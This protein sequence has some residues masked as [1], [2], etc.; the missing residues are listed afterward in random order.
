VHDAFCGGGNIVGACLSRGIPATGSDLRDRGY[1]EQRDAFNITEPFDNLISNPPFSLIEDIIPHFLPLVRHKMILMAR[2]NI[3]E[4]I[5]RRRLF[6][7]MPPVRVW[8]S[9]QRISCPP[10][11]LQHPR[12]EFGC[13][14]PLPAS[15]G[16]TTYCWLVWDKAYIGPT[17]L[18]WLPLKFDASHALRHR[19][20]PQWPATPTAT[21]LTLLPPEPVVAS[22]PARG[23]TI[24]KQL[25]Q[26]AKGDRVET[27]D[28][29]G[30]R[31]SGTIIVL[32]REVDIFDHMPMSDAA[33]AKFT[34]ER[35]E[36]VLT[37]PANGRLKQV[38]IWQRVVPEVAAE[39]P[40]Q[41]VGAQPNGKL[42]TLAIPVQAALAWAAGPDGELV[43]DAKSRRVFAKDAAGQVVG[44]GMGLVESRKQEDP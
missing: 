10:G 8:V 36:R 17:I 19:T 12:D 40:T 32:L 34:P 23:A 42:I 35:L 26:I 18:G 5:E 4:G 2:I 44:V 1:G 24:A 16:T 25:L 9:S 30:A 33:S 6:D 13:V 22:T 41:I 3:L 11:H 39:R 43:A 21:S 7:E 15:G 31:W 37:P 28:K 27:R 20:R 38:S 29:A 14:V